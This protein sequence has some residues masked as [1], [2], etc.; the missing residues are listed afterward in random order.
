MSA[1][2]TYESGAPVPDRAGSI[3][4]DAAEAADALARLRRVYSFLN[5]T[6]EAIARIKE[7]MRLFD[8]ACR[9]AVE[10]GGFRMAWIGLVDEDTGQIR[11]V[12]H[13]GLEDGYLERIFVSADGSDREGRGPTG[14][15]ARTGT[16]NICKDFE[17]DPRMTPWRAEALRRGYL[18]SGAFPLRIGDRVV[19]AL[20]LYAAEKDFFSD[21]EVGLFSSLAE[22]ISHAIDAMEKEEL[23]KL[24]E[25]EL[26][27]KAAMLDAATD[28]IFV[29]DR[30]GDF[31]YA[32][33][34]SWK[35]R[36]YSREQ[37]M[38]LNLMDLATPEYA[39]LVDE[40]LAGAGKTGGVFESA[41]VR[42]DG[43]VMEVEVHLR[44]VDAHSRSVFLSVA[45]DITERKKAERE[46]GDYREHLEE[47]VDER[48]RHLQLLNDEL[49]SFSYSVSHDLRSPLRAIDGFSHMLLEDVGAG[50]TEDDR[51]SFDYIFSSVRRMDA[52][53]EGLLG[54]ARVGRSEM[55]TSFQEMNGLVESVVDE[56]MPGASERSVEILIG[57][58]PDASCDMVL[59]Q[60]VVA[61]LLS[62]ALKFT[63]NADNALIEIQGE[64]R[65]GENVYLIRDN[66]TGFDPAHADRLF[67][68]F[69]RLHDVE[70]YEGTG[71][72]LALV[73][74]IVLRHGG[75]VWAESAPGE[76]ATFFFS[77]PAVS[78]D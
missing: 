30:N 24:V 29:V 13:R 49:E 37:F 71:V 20:T 31:I 50:L 44:R 77:L 35:T 28:S 78:K 26:A 66:G 76:G 3:V 59:M 40:R 42:K 1:E 65:D 56:V 41:H 33:E 74:R 57:D 15:A 52:I 68:V 36:G 53:I 11:P 7:P 45:R 25:E 32:N 39:L 19:G 5:M 63:R 10:V 8:E 64:V 47:L 69:Q 14:T 2:E 58:L 21:E 22:D 54:L 18:S 38:K 46:L 62:N 43:S 70:E 34:A 48:T 4:G 60:Q 51:K 27:L 6:N 75:R 61:N 23:R 55:R 72:G 9:I 16:I 73:R 12:V 17:T 67:G